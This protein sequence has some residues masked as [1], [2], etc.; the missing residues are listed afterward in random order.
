[1]GLVPVFWGDGSCI[2]MG[3]ER[4]VLADKNTEG[5]Q[6]ASTPLAHCV[7]ALLF[8]GEAAL[9]TSSQGIS[10]DSAFPLAEGSLCGGCQ[11]SGSHAEAEQHSSASKP[12]PC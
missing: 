4:R 1:M 11:H 8:L 10:S 3:C 7:M 12:P 9:P 6:K 5:Y 2:T